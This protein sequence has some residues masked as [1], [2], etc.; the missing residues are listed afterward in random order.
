[1]RFQLLKLVC[2]NCRGRAPARIR[3]VGL[4]AKGQL[5]IH[6]RCIRCRRNVYTIKC[7]EE[8]LRKSGKPQPAAAADS[9]ELMAKPDAYFLRSMGVRPLDEE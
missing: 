2:C 9:Q 7:L 8:C 6:W 3:R 5:V 4:T 1:M